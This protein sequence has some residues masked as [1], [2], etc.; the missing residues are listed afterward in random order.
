MVIILVAFHAFKRS[1]ITYALGVMYL[2]LLSYIMWIEMSGTARKI[3]TTWNQQTDKN[4][5]QYDL[6]AALLLTALFTTL[7]YRFIF[8]LPSRRFYRMTQK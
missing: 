8:G 5:S 3:A 2:M 6:V 4:Q 1:R 7:L